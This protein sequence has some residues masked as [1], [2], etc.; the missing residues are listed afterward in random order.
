[1]DD[2]PRCGTTLE[3]ISLGDRSAEFCN[4]CGFADLPVTHESEFEDV[5]TWSDAIKRFYDTN[6]EKE[7]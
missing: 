2:C 3:S 6:A 4:K 7:E 5:E 1:M